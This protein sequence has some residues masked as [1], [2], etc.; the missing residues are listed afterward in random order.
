MVGVP[1][2]S[3]NGYEPLSGAEREERAT[4]TREHRAP[5]RVVIRRAN[6]SAFNGYRWTPS[7]YSGLTCLACLRYWRTCAAYVDGTPDIT[8]EEERARSAGI[9]VDVAKLSAGVRQ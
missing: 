1:A 3:G 9:R 2:V 5:W 8:R 4:C 6:T 7:R